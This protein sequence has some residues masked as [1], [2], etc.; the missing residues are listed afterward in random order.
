MPVI[1]DPDFLVDGTDVVV[2]TTNRTI[3]ILTTGGVD[4]EGATG[5]VTGQALYSWLKERWK[6]NADYIKFPFPME[7]ITPEQFEFINGWKPFDDATRK[8]IRTAGWAERSAAGVVER[9]YA[10]V[11]SLGSL[12]GTDQ[13]YYQFG[14]GAATNFTYTGP[15]NEAVQ[16]FGDATNGNF[17]Y[18]DG[19]PFKLFCREQGKTYASSNNAAIGAATLS[20]ITYRFPLSNGTDLKIDASDAT[21]ASTA[22]Y[23]AI[24]I[25]YFG[26]DQMYDVD[27][28]SINEPYRIVIQGATVATTQQIYEKVQYLLRQPSDIDTGAGTVVGRTAD[29][30]LRFVGDTLV[31]A[32]GV[33][34]NALNDNFLNSVD[35]YDFNGVVRR[36]PFVSAGT[37]NFGANAGAGDFIYRAFFADG[38]G[39]ASAVIVNDKDGNP[40]QGTFTGASVPFSFAYDSNSQGGRTPGTNASVKLVGLGLDGG[41]FASVDFTITRSQGINV[42]LAPALERNYNNPV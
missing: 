28:D 13:P 37:I 31:G 8:L 7:S 4:N 25:E 9:L 10:G 22:P 19:T 12:G 34:I 18:T 38:Y 36:Y 20:Y 17:N 42:L 16:I 33:Y 14:S 23:T 2:N 41:Q 11:V 1:F 21:I 15:I 40:I 5:G 24:S 27:G 35:F 3:R 6:A 39:T 30:L 26:T 29:E 32:N